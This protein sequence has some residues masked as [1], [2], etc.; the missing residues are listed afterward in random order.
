MLAGVHRGCPAALVL[1]A[2]RSWGMPEPER[3]DLR[4][5]DKSLRFQLYFI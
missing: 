3:G 5:K 4:A 2:V 1:P